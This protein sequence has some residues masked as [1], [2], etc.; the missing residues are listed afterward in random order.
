[1]GACILFF[2]AG[3]VALRMAQGLLQSDNA[4]HQSARIDRIVF[5]EKYPE[6]AKDAVEM[7][8]AC[9]GRRI[10]LHGMD[11]TDPRL[12]TDLLRSTSPDLIIQAASMI[13][14]WQIFGIDHPVAHALSTGG[15]ALQAPTQLPVLLNVMR[16][17]RELDL[18]APV[19]NISMPD[20]AH[21]V[22]DKIGL[23]PDIGL[24]NVSILHLRARA[25]LRKKLDYPPSEQ[26]PPL[27]LI[28][29]HHHV[30]GSMHANPPDDSTLA[31]RIYVGDTF[32]RDDSL[33]Y[34]GHP[35]PTGPV[36]NVVT[37][38]SAIPVMHA[39]L[40]E[41]RDLQ[42][43]APAPLGLPGGYP[44]RI[45]NRKVT[46]DLPQGVALDEAVTFNQSISALDGLAA[47]DDDG[48]I[49]F[50]GKAQDSVRDID[51]RLAEPLSI[52]GM[53]ARTVLLLE[54][55]SEIR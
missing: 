5:A 37:A 31:A 33:A 26:E 39:L 42:F 2:G 17:I 22:L 24:G 30:Y 53:K 7:L 48:T 27:R 9:T 41:G 25:T 12:V 21:A 34:A 54:T 28:A 36:Y 14:P 13:G 19:A 1:M 52:Q 20:I 10:K 55:V 50:T 6:K 49:H 23:T 47:V 40:P 43:S 8:A 38:A 29:H 51:P 46:L 45:Q 35:F 4:L 18:K 11:G 3:D 15:I 16:C 44:V 32:E